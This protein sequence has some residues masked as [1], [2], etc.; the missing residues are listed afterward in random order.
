MNTEII[1]FVSF[2]F[3]SDYVKR[4]NMEQINYNE[5]P[6]R[7][8]ENYIELLSDFEKLKAIMGLTRK[9]RQILIDLLLIA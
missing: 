6:K 9:Q 2:E 8:C 5:L 7:F 4:I 3:H 1:E